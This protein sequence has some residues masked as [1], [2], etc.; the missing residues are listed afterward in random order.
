MEIKVKLSLQF[1]LIVFGI[2]LFFAGLVYYFSASSQLGIFRDDLLDRAKNTGIL[3]IN[4]TEVDS[5]LLKKIHQSTISWKNEEI[6]LTDSAMKIVYSNNPDYLSESALKQHIP[7]SDA[8]YFSIREKDGVGYRH[9]FNNRT[10]YV[11]V[12][13]FDFYRKQNLKELIDVLFWSS[14]IST[15]LSVYL[16]YIF[17]QRAIRPISRL[18]SSI[19]AINSSRLSSRLDEG[20]G[21]DEIAQLAIAFNEMLRNL[22]ISFQN[23]ADFISNASHE[24]RT[25]LTVMN[26]ES[27]YILTR[28]RTTD[29]YKTHISGLITDVRKLNYLLNSLLELAHLNRDVNIQLSDIRLDEVIYTSIHQVKSR[30]HD[31]K[32]LL[33]ITYPENENDLLV[34]GNPGL[35]TIAFNNL[36]ENACKFSEGE[37]ITEFIIEER[38]IKII[39]SD[40]GIGIPSDQMIDIFTPFKRASNVKYKSGFGIGLSLVAK[41]LKVHGVACNVQS[42]ENEGT[43]FELLFGRVSG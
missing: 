25:P 9:R 10:Y 5:T 6:V 28:E 23:Q 37:V 15:F 30:Y 4:V 31:R 14:I 42:S 41:I 35:L 33:R 17:S 26:I 7:Q 1:T 11:Y 38:F 21:T 34:R 2:L 36:L 8:T 12:M 20:N 39:I 3:L 32:I 40:D 18:I 27:D 19:R 24:L 16:S 13:A 29:E 22:E 43:K